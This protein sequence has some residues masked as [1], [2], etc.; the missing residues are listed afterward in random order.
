MKRILLLGPPGAGKGT[1]ADK[2]VAQLGIPKI[3]TGDMFRQAIAAQTPLGKQVE[4]IMQA[5]E[6]VSDDIVVAM[7]KDRLSQP[8]CQQGFLLD[9]FPRTLAQAQA[10]DAA[11]VDV[12]LVLTLEVPHEQI[13][14]RMSGRRVHP[15]SG[16]VYH[17]VFNPPKTAGLDDMT[18][19]P[20]IQR[21]DDEV[22]TVCERLKIYDQRTLPM[23]AYYREKAQTDHTVQ[24]AAIAGTN[25]VDAVFAAIKAYLE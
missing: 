10:L 3:S 13:I 5:G 20:L 19:E 9:G 11:G 4:G 12:D 22:D 21:K 17:T 2:I 25:P 15:G 18:G 16:R 6:L 14:E 1:Q 23:V 24:Y 7:V 8:D